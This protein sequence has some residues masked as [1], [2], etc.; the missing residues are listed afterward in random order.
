MKTVFFVLLMRMVDLGH[1][2]QMH[3][4]VNKNTLF[5]GGTIVM[6]HKICILQ[7]HVVVHSSNDLMSLPKTFLKTGI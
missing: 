6:K 3:L 2:P 7:M 4:H 1:F 5:G